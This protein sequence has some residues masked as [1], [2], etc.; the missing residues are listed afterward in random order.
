MAKAKIYLRASTYDYDTNAAGDESGL[1][2]EDKSLTQQH[3][4]DECD[5]N[6]LME[7]F[8]VRGEIP[9]LPEPPIQGDFTNIM[10]MQEALN[11][12]IQARESFMGLD[13]KI[14]ARF[15]HDPAKFVDFASDPA[16]S[17]QMRQWGHWSEEAT[18]AFE[19]KAKAQ[20]DADEANRRDAEAYRASRKEAKGDV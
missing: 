8:V 17:E 11:L 5:I 2:C 12:Q 19:A 9:Q 7:R 13:A 10:T 16:N 20:R 14:R 6:V 15:D 4:K 3:M 1:R 18:A